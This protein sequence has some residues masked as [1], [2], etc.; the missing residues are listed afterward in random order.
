MIIKILIYILGLI[1]GA[2]LGISWCTYYL[3]KQR[4]KAERTRINQIGINVNEL[5]KQMTEDK[6]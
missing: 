2:S 4:K 1:H 3:K 5:L 6:Q